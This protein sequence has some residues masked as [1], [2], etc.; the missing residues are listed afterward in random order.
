M[1]HKHR[2]YGMIKRCATYYK[3]W[4]LALAEYNV[5]EL[6]DAKN[7]LIRLGYLAKPSTDIPFIRVL[8]HQLRVAAYDVL[9]MPDCS[10]VSQY[11]GER[12]NPLA[13]RV[14]AVMALDENAML[15]NFISQLP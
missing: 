4:R 15:W 6:E 13:S 3:R 11:Y 7:L 1:L 12:R 10:W 2:K 9:S 14:A 8:A 5:C